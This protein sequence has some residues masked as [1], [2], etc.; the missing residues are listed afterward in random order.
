MAILPALRDALW[1]KV[2]AEQR[3]AEFHAEVDRLARERGLQNEP[4]ARLSLSTEVF[5][6]RIAESGDR[7][8]R[9]GKWGVVI[10]L[11]GI[12]LWTAI[13]LAFG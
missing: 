13:V 3:I 2:D 11:M 10:I 1:P 4:L 9:R 8:V 6:R 12:A 5:E 7:F